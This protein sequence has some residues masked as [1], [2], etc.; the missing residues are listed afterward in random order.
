MKPLL[1]ILFSALLL[2][3]ISCKTSKEARS[4]RTT[5][6]GSWTVTDVRISGTNGK[7][8]AKVFGEADYSCFIGSQWN[9]NTSTSIGTYSL[10]TGAACSVITRKIRWSI[11]EIKGEPKQLQFKRLNEKEK[12]IDDGNGYR[13][14]IN[15]ISQNNMEV[16]SEL[17]FEGKPIQIIYNFSKN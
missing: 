15:S 14:T 16:Q 13:L 17:I 4:I 2:G 7:F 10:G 11:Y 5:V 3:T 8:K 12:D 9:F 1:S 6:K